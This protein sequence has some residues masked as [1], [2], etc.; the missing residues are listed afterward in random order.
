MTPTAPPGARRPQFT[1]P[2]MGTTP[3]ARAA[4]DYVSVFMPI[5]AVA[6]LV[7][8]IYVATTG[9]VHFWPAAIGALAV[10]VVSRALGKWLFR[11]RKVRTYRFHVGEFILSLAQFAAIAGLAYVLFGADA[12]RSVVFGYGV[13]VAAA[14]ALCVVVVLPMVRWAIKARE[15]EERAAVARSE[16]KARARAAYER[17]ATDSAL[18]RSSTPGQYL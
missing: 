12:A 14:G 13:L 10:F 15:K 4:L 16:A 2:L 5:S 17:V 1:G 18:R 3:E 11:R 9:P 6:Y 8:A 7:L